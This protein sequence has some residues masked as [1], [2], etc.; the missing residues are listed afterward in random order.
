MAVPLIDGNT[1]DI[2]A[3]T[4]EVT[5]HQPELETSRPSLLV[6]AISPSINTV[7]VDTSTNN[8]ETAEEQNDLLVENHHN[9]LIVK[10]Q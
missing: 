6:T 3:F 9:Q 1:L 10:D 8:F 5:V 2:S 7:R 4:R